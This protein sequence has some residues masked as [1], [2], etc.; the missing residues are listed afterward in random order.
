MRP[1]ATILA[2]IERHK[3]FRVQY[4]AKLDAEKAR[5]RKNSA[6]ILHLETSI[7]FANDTLQY[8]SHEL[9][10]VRSKK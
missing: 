5:K 2:E 9:E 10:W 7:K 6:A 8:L 1:A 3:S 4:H